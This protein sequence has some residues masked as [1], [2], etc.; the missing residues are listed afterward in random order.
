MSDKQSPRPSNTA[1]IWMG[2]LQFVMVG[3]LGAVFLPFVYIL[4]TG[5][6]ETLMTALIS[7]GIAMIVFAPLYF[8]HG[9]SQRKQFVAG[10]GDPL[11]MNLWMF[12]AMGGDW[13]NR[14]SS[15]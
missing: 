9:A 15:N 1:L 14:E 13:K 4:F 8:K 3:V 2:I 12:G 6:R 5:Q 10:G 11:N 7:A